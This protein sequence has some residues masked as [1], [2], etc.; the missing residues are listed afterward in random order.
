MNYVA[1][2][3]CVGS[4]GFKW[5]FFFLSTGTVKMFVNET[6]H[7]VDVENMLS[8]FAVWVPKRW[9][10]Q[11]CVQI[12][13]VT[14]FEDKAPII[15]VI[16]FQFFEISFLVALMISCDFPFVFVFLKNRKLALDQPISDF[17]QSRKV[18][19]VQLPH[20]QNH[21]SYCLSQLWR[22]VLSPI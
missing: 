2:S 7:G 18:F 4:E 14:H 21:Y 16:L 6:L 8:Y 12:S 19:V 9:R 1:Q 17:P 3:C 15:N 5:V 13:K 22:S 10:L 11:G 20:A